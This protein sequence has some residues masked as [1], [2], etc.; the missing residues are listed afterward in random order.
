MRFPRPHDTHLHTK[1]RMAGNSVESTGTAVPA[2]SH[3][4][5]RTMG[6]VS[7]TI[8]GVGDMLG[9]GI[10]ALVGKAAGIM[11]NAVWLAFAAS[12]VPALLTG[13]SYACIGSRY[14]R[15]AGAAYVTHRAYNY[16]FLSYVVGLA[17]MASGLT[18]M[19][20]SSRAFADY[21]GELHILGPVPFPAIVVAFVLFVAWINF[22]GMRESAWMNAVCTSVEVFG[23][24]FV[25]AVGA[26][27]WGGDVDYFEPP[28]PGQSLS[29][30]LVLSGAV[31]T[32]FS[33]VGFEDLLNVAEEVKEPERTLP[34]GIIL[35]MI[36]TTIIYM[37]VSVTAI[38]VVRHDELAASD[39]PLLEVVRRAAPWFPQN[40]FTVVCAFA[41]SNTVLLNYVMASRLAYGMARQG[42]LPRFLGHVHPR[43]RTPHLA[44]LT[45]M[46][47][48][49]FLALTTR[50]KALGEATSLLL[51]MVFV[52]VNGALIVLKLRPNEPRGRFEVPI[53]VP[54]LGVLA[55]STLLARSLMDPD[56][57]TA[58]GLASS[59][60]LVIVILFFVMRPRAIPEHL[61]LDDAGTAGG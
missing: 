49:L 29:T 19:A 2:H 59:I 25:V 52:V 37:L 58:L 43:R 55:C 9:S 30:G 6:L 61:E 11:G 26:R 4:L 33:F 60:L 39:A 13:L 53:V 21:L 56:K 47:T 7:L 44:I 34:W 17:V 15:A 5:V 45:L 42:L 48:V 27:F 22:R 41:V 46:V 3:T 1:G 57:W 18:S 8:Y 32:F 20:T 40:V 14:P 16:T 31:L 23:L 51:L 38:S 50:V 54:G 12:M 24:L 36:I 28:R 35:A 10:Y